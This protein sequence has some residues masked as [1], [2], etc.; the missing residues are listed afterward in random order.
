MREH[1]TLRLARTARG[2]DY[3]REVYVEAAAGRSARHTIVAQD[4]GEGG[5]FWQR[6]ST[7]SVKVT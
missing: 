4:I 3:R 1:H 5:E 6:A 2:I 7:S